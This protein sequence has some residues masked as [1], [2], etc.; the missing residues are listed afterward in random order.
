MPI[1]WA[2]EYRKVPP[3]ASAVPIQLSIEIGFLKNATLLRMTTTRFIV[4]PTYH[5][6]IKKC[7]RFRVR[8]VRESL[9]Q[10]VRAHSNARLACLLSAPGKTADVPFN[11]RGEFDVGRTENVTAEIPVSAM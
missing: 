8:M 4:F 10:S 3:I 9:D 7:I 1:S 2:C 5:N 11:Q 6:G